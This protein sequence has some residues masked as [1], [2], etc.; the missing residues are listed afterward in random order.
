MPFAQKSLLIGLWLI[1]L[2]INPIFAAELIP[3][4]VGTATF[5]VEVAKTPEQREHGLMFRR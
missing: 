4:T 3:I 2:T 5:Q 1:A